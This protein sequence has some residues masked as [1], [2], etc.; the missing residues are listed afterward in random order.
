MRGTPIVCLMSA[1]LIS[2]AGLVAGEQPSPNKDR[3]HLFNP[4]PRELM[5]EMSTDRPD[6]TES[7]YTVDAGHFQI[8]M[9][10]VS[11]GYDRHNVE[12]IDARAES[13]S[14][15]NANLKVGLTNRVDLQLVVPMYNETR[16]RI[17]G[18]TVSRSQGFGDLIARMKIN[19]WGNDGGRTA[20]A[21]MPFVKVP[22]N[23]DDL[24]NDAVEGGLILPLAVELPGGWGMGL[25]AEVD[26]NED[27]DEGGY[28]A[29]FVNSLTVGHA[30]VGELNGYV[31]FVSVA[32][33]ERDGDWIGT[34]NLGVT[35]AVTDDLQ[36][37][38]GVNLGVSRAADDVN[39]F[40]GISWRF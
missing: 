19:V 23:G 2:P 4:T 17:S 3:Y 14:F 1:L 22:T 15:A 39:P 11:L 38:A 40:V 8:E 31:E 29:D 35:F 12:R 18:G 10:L 7:P 34:V 28:H 25:M 16:T 32:T 33:T 13:W 21:L 30:I 26:F 36:L 9:D 6:V 20:F 24:G 5:R 27:E 37:D